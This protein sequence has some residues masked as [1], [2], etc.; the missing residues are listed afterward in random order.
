MDQSIVEYI[1][2]HVKEYL[3]PEY[4]DAAVEV[5]EV[6]KNNDRV[7]T[8]LS[9]F[10]DGNNI[11]PTIYLEPYGE[12]I[13]AGR[14]MAS[15]LEEI[16]RIQQRESGRADFS[17]SVL[18]DY[19]KVRPMLSVRLCDPEWN[20]GYLK[21]KPHTACG[22]LAAV[23][24]VQVMA[25]KEGTASIAVT[26]DM[27]R[28]WGVTKERLHQDAAEAESLR[29]PPRLY[30]LKDIIFDSKWEDMF[31][32]AGPLQAGPMPM[33]V[34]TNSNMI[35]GAGVAAMEGVLDRVGE[36]LGKDFYVLPSSVNEVMIL[37][38]NGVMRTKDLEDM[39]REIN[40]EEVAPHEQLSEK[41]QYYDR[42]A[43][44]LG[45]KKEKGLLEQL[46]DNKRLAGEK[47]VRTEGDKVRRAEKGGPCL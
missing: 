25:G 33:Y 2:R 44:T 19:G 5:R 46:A 30:R 40:H 29:N 39:V 34:L 23:Y 47:N 1:K 35:D 28:L 32:A 9:I 10:K 12:D 43:K 16:A 27:M 45:R 36:L 3:P 21:D 14:S 37:P 15:V 13:A 38:D 26:Y 24:R 11:T 8:G 17:P 42:A 6:M 7:M 18:R 31:E 20:P 4:R 22:E 41:V